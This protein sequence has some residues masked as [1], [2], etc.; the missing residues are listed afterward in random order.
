M[1]VDANFSAGR[2]PSRAASQDEMRDGRDARQCLSAEAERADRAEIL[3]AGDLTGRVPFDR[4]A[5]VLRHH[6]VAVVFHANQLLATELDGDGDAAGIRVERVLD[7]LF[8]DRRGPLND[9]ARR[10]LV[11][12]VQRQPADA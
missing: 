6:P 11:R 2:L 9:L 12:E 8:N 5:R 3:R 1:P 4:Q 10:D 7:E